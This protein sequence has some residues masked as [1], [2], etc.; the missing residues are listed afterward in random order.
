MRQQD[1]HS[2]RAEKTVGEIRRAARRHFSVEEKIRV[3]LE[4]P[5]GEECGVLPTHP[6]NSNTE[7]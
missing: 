2:Q 5:R 6:A 3:V 7:G 1:P 4:G